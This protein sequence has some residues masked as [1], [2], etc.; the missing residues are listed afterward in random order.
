MWRRGW[1]VCGGPRC[2]ARTAWLVLASSNHVPRPSPPC[3]GISDGDVQQ[4]RAGILG[5]TAADVAAFARGPLQAV[6]ARGR[7]CVVGS[8]AA[9]AQYADEAAA[10]GGRADAP[11]FEL[12]RPLQQRQR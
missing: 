4:R 11:Q 1:G 9:F 2:A 6:A 8:E 10:A 12:V 3:A 5:V 7:V